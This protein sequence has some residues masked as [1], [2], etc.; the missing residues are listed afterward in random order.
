M[1]ILD[2]DHISVLQHA[3]S[4]AAQQLRQR[5]AD[6]GEPVATTSVTVE[7]QCRSWL[8]LINRYSDVRRQVTYYDRFVEAIRFFAKWRILPFDERAADEFQRH[9]RGRVRIA[10][11]DLKIAAVALVQGGMLLSSNL[12]DFERVPG[13]R[14]EDWVTS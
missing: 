12:R 11:T 13:L 4:D 3:Q 9:R 2:T 14:V 7:E 1:I 5:L 6:S 8:A 10:T